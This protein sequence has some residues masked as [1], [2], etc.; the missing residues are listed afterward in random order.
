M[1]SLPLPL[2]TLSGVGFPTHIEGLPGQRRC[3][4]QVEV[5]ETVVGVGAST[6]L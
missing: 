5:G 4:G 6:Q 2:G 3:G 1:Q